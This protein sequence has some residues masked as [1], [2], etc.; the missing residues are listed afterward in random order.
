LFL[1]IREKLFEIIFFL[2]CGG[3]LFEIIFFLKCGGK[4]FEI[5]FFLKCGGKLFEKSFPPH[6]LSKTFNNITVKMRRFISPILSNV[7]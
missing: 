2:K 6:P 1:F 4:L 3:K 7:I 5:I